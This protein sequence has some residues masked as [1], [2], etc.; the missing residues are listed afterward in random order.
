MIKDLELDENLY[1]IGQS[2]LFF[3]AGVL[4]HLEEERTLKLSDIIIQFQALCRGVNS[5]YKRYNRKNNLLNM[6][7]Y[8]FL[9]PCSACL[10]YV[11]FPFIIFSLY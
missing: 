6:L 10:V 1:R 4:A 2:K 8:N 7:L 11:I 3:R 5:N 9:L